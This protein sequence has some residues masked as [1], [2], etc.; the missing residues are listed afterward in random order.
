MGISDGG[1]DPTMGV[2]NT[3]LNLRLANQNVISS[4]IANADTPGYKAK[5]IEFEGAL[6]EALSTSNRTALS[7]AYN[8]LNRSCGTEAFA[9]LDRGIGDKVPLQVK[10]YTAPAPMAEL[11]F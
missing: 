9:V 4:N 3:A 5:K 7:D 6:R 1:F 11:S 2:L 8:T 10:M